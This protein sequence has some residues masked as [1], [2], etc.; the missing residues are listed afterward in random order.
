[1][2]WWSAVLLAS[3]VLSL[4]LQAQLPA[5]LIVLHASADPNL[6]QLDAYYDEN[7]IQFGLRFREQ[8]YPPVELFPGSP[9]RVSVAPAG[10]PGGPDSAIASLQL[11]PQEGRV[12]WVAVVGV[13]QPS[14]FAPNPEGSSIAVRLLPALAPAESPEPT[15]VWLLLL[16]AVTDAVAVRLQRA[17]GEQLFPLTSFGNTAAGAL[18]PADTLTLELVRAN[19]E[20]VAR[21]RG[22]LRGV[23]G[24]A[25]VLLLSGFAQPAQNQ[26]GPAVELRAVFPYGNPVV[27]ER[28]D[29]GT[30]T[31]QVQLIH[32][33]TEPQL[34]EMDLYLDGVKRVEDFAFGQA[35]PLT[36]VPAGVPLRVGIA[37]GNSQSERD[38]LRSFVAIL[39]PGGSLCAVALGVLEPVRF[40]PN[41][42]GR[43]TELSLV[44]FP[45]RERASGADSVLLAVVHAVTDAPAVE[46]RWG[47]FTLG[48]LSYADALPYRSLPPGLDTLRGLPREYVLDLSTDGGKAAVLVVTGFAQPAANQNGPEL[49]PI[50][51]FP[52]GTVRRL[53]PVVSV[54]KAHAQA[55]PVRFAAPTGA[56]LHLQNLPN[57]PAGMLRVE[58]WDI[59]GQPVLRW[60]GM[61]EGASYRVP[62]SAM[63][64]A[65]AYLYRMSVEPAGVRR[66]GVVLL[67]GQ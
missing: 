59:L 47:A 24:E 55:L 23:A 66:M 15:R 53:S 25:G 63:L 6:E 1:M 50:L 11:T 52:D 26:G 36:Q 20:V 29:T 48:R 42:E 14:Q 33:S 32:A 27:F 21:F 22:D 62:L 12:H 18:V 43:P 2:R 57:L 65:G 38:T 41:P 58:L 16:H 34:R 17:T 31:A 5:Q 13:R 51:V 56:E 9:V 54:G 49:Q 40:A 7:W 44:G 35:T 28:V 3:I 37:P 19:G 8:S 64:P 60:Q 67:P 46:L 61:P 39:P 4:P 30:P 45:L 10:N